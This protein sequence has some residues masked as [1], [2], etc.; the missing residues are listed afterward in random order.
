MRK[1]LPST[2]ARPLLALYR[3]S[4]RLDR[5]VLILRTDSAS[6]KTGKRGDSWN[7]P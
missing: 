1:L 3:P 2:F 5:F 7:I 6:T 4:D